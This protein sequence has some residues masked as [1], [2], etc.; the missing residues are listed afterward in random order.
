MFFF[1]NLFVEYIC[2][3]LSKLF[4]YLFVV[5]F[6]L[7][8]SFRDRT[9]NGSAFLFQLY[10]ALFMVGNS[11]SDIVR[12][13]VNVSEM[14]EPVV[15]KLMLDICYVRPCVVRHVDSGCYPYT[16]GVL[17]ALHI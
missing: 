14:V 10:S 12:R 6:V 5:L 15:I 16:V 8:V 9:L 2:I 3:S 17:A 4:V 7:Y 1:V 11:Y 13:D